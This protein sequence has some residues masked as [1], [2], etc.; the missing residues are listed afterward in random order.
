MLKHD[1][2][3][4]MLVPLSEYERILVHQF[5]SADV[6]D[7]AVALSFVTLGAA[8]P[9]YSR[10]ELG[11]DA[12]TGLR[13][14]VAKF[15]ADWE[16]RVYDFGVAVQLYQPSAKLDDHQLEYLGLVEHEALRA[17]LAPLAFPKQ[18]EL[19]DD[20]DSRDVHVHHYVISVRPPNGPWLHC[21][22]LATEGIQP[23]RTKFAIVRGHGAGYFDTLSAPVYYLDPRTFDCI[24]RGDHLFIINKDK[25]ERIFELEEDVQAGARLVAHGVA[26]RLPFSNMDDFVAACQRDRRMAA[27][28][29]RMRGLPHLDLLSIERA[30][31]AKERFDL[32]IEF[33]RAPDGTEM[34]K[35]VPRYKW[36]YV[37]ILG[38][39]YVTS[40]VTGLDYESNSK[41]PLKKRS[42]V[43][44]GRGAL[45]ELTPRAD[46]TSHN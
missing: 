36:Q 29:A 45:Q 16:H 30:K 3:M 32:D 34:L 19:L 41:R 13:T 33:E 20:D 12:A 24:Y 2:Q 25:F 31:L 27:K 15:L 26:D 43:T 35:F 18:L 17:R 46:H 22:R 23:Q 6:A 40:P 44:M 28:V 11:P 7:S 8:G 1:K 21:F 4:R 42:R 10:V 5:T 37:S 9:Q 39:E 38:D 14:M